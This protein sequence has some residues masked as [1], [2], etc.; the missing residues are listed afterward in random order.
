MRS[1]NSLK[2]FGHA[3]K[4][5]SQKQGYKSMID[6]Q[7]KRGS[8]TEDKLETDFEETASI[9]GDI[10]DG[11]PIQG[12]TK[13]FTSF[14]TQIQE[15]WGGIVLTILLTAFVSLVGWV[16]LEV[17]DNSKS[18]AVHENRLNDLDSYLQGLTD[19]FSVVRD[20]S[21]K[22]ETLLESLEQYVN[23]IIGVGN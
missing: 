17:V 15:R 14:K 9:D 20:R 3:T 8:T 19:D 6:G 7:Q 18:V 4:N 21:L 11:E 16:L 2:K 5:L 1:K 12:S 23:Q 13:P 10:V 22:S